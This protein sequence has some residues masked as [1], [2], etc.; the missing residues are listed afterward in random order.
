MKFCDDSNAVK[1]T[2][3]LG[4]VRRP[5]LNKN[6]TFRGLGSL[7]ADGGRVQYPQ[8]RVLKPDDGNV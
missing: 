7:S 1:I 8:R 2:D 6:T 4:I 5:G 3:L